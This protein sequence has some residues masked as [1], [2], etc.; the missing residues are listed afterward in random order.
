[1][2]NSIKT[3]D[4][5]T[6]RTIDAEI[7]AALNVVAAKFGITISLRGGS[8]SPTVCNTK[9]EIKSASHGVAGADPIKDSR[10]KMTAMMLDLPEDIVGK[11]F[12]QIRPGGGKDTFTIT[13]LDSKKPKYPVIATSSRDNKSYKFTAGSVRLCLTK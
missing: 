5:P 7:Q 13:G 12:E 9:I 10:N 11:T 2:E 6:L 8:F 1:M 3:F 4:K